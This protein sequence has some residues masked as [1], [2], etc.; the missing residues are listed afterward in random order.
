MLVVL[1]GL[2][3]FAGSDIGVRSGSERT[4]LLNLLP[5]LKQDN[6][7]VFECCL[8]SSGVLRP[9]TTGRSANAAR[10]LDHQFA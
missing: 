9:R 8:L 3:L 4:M 5:G 7:V 6:Q 10:F 2:D 1:P